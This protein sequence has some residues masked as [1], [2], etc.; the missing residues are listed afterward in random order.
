MGF[1]FPMTKM[2]S[3]LKSITYPN[4]NQVVWVGYSILKI[5]YQMIR[6]LIN[7][8]KIKNRLVGY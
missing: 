6:L 7:Y 8:Q 1:F 2:F 5:Q 3:I 4:D